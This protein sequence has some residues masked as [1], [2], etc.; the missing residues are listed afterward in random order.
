MKTRFTALKGAPDVLPPETNLW[1]RIEN[2]ACE[3]FAAYG[4]DEIKTS[5]IEPAEL[6]LRS[7]GASSDIVAKEMYSFTDKGGRSVS[8][9]PE[10]TA[11]VVRAYVEHN[12]SLRPAP[13]KFFYRGPMFRYERPQKGRQRQ[14]YQIGA[15][16]FGTA[17]PGMDA[18]LIVM[19]MAFLERAG[20]PALSL[21]LNSI[22]CRNCRPAFKQRLREFFAPHLDGLCPDCQ[23]RHEQNPLRILDCKVERCIAIRAGAPL[24]SESLCAECREHFGAL[25]GLLDAMKTPYTLNPHMVRGLDYY[26]R[27]VFEVTSGQLGAQNAV[28]AGG[29]YDLLVSE[30]GG[31][32]TPAL[33]FAAGMERLSRLLSAAESL[34]MP[35]PEVFIASLGREAAAAALSTASALRARDKRV[36]V[37][38]EGSLK[39]QLRRADKMGARYVVIIG[40]DELRSGSFKW[41]NLGTGESG[42]TGAE[43]IFNLLS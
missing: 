23:R 33:G 37:G 20:L 40:E 3:V 1:G 6:F 4:Y 12:L 26:T 35:R 29:R 10:G 19:L 30:F 7:I 43:E 34:S 38:W 8:L 25:L 14:F 32:E 9:R 17:H 15:E 28:A 41:K 21:E 36:E 18:E 22:G 11:S 16:C 31:P 2:A 24:I 39:S 5:I 27:T 13:Q 42:E